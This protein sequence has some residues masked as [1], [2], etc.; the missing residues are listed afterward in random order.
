MRPTGHVWAADGGRGRP[1]DRRDSTS[2]TRASMG[3]EYAFRDPLSSGL[4]RETGE[5]GAGGIPAGGLRLV[6]AAGKQAGA[7]RRSRMVRELRTVQFPSTSCCHVPP[8]QVV[9]RHRPSQ[10][11]SARPCRR[12]E[13]QGDLDA[14]LAAG[15]E[16]VLEDSLERP[17]AP[18]EP[19]FPRSYLLL[20]LGRLGL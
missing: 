6:S 12:Q 2:G 1:P 7:R 19:G 10:R 17:L 18:E 11:A 3:A 9:A 5:C 4:G 15:P 14:P 20:A 16:V 13:V 8:A